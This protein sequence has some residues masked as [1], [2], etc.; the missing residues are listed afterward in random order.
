MKYLYVL[1]AVCISALCLAE[2]PEDWKKSIENGNISYTMKR[3]PPAELAPKEYNDVQRWGLMAGAVLAYHNHFF[4]DSFETS[5]VDN[6]WSMAEDKALLESSWGITCREDY[7][8]TMRSLFSAGHRAGFKRVSNYAG[9]INE[10]Y[11][12]D[13]FAGSVDKP[14][15]AYPLYIAKE[16]GPQ[17]KDKSITGWDFTRVIYLSRNCSKLG[18]ISEQLAWEYIYEASVIL[19]R[20]FDSWD[21]L[22][23]NYIIGRNFWSFSSS[24]ERNARFNNEIRRLKKVKDSSAFNLDWNLKLSKEKM[25]APGQQADI[26]TEPVEM[27]FELSKSIQLSDIKEQF[28]NVISVPSDCKTIEKAMERAQAGDCIYA[29]KGTYYF[30]EPLVFKTGVSLIGQSRDEVVL[31]VIKTNSQVIKLK[32]AMDVKLCN[33]TVKQTAFNFD[34]ENTSSLLGLGKSSCAVENLK[35]EGKSLYGIYSRGDKVKIINCE[36]DTKQLCIYLR[37][38]K[39]EIKGCL[40][41]GSSKIGIKNKSS[42][43]TVSDTY[44]A[45]KGAGIA[46]FSA[47]LYVADC[48]IENNRYGISSQKSSKMN[49]SDTFIVSNDT[50]CI[51]QGC[52]NFVVSDVQFVG[53]SFGFR[54]N[55]AENSKTERNLFYLN[56]MQ[57]C[58]IRGDVESLNLK[59]NI[60]RKNGFAGLDIES[61]FS[62]QLIVDN[63]L[64]DEN[65][66]FAMH[67]S[68]VG[69]NLKGNI[70]TRTNGPALYLT[71]CPQYDP[72]DGNEFIDNYGI[73]VL[74]SKSVDEFCEKTTSITRN[75][76]FKNNSSLLNISHEP[77][78]EHGWP[79]DK[80][81]KY[82]KKLEETKEKAEEIEESEG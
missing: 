80:Y 69:V 47:D 25:F 82:M 79:L 48:F 70:F 72:I 16:F 3:N 45:G 43:L 15:E 9:K 21:E 14:G 78:I 52:N 26:E 38:K 29:E 54:I 20:T 77:E 8:S 12:D 57:G 74:V 30:Q 61:R 28:E 11:F 5:C 35:V 27:N 23:D 7:L 55:F 73:P 75:N 64:F 42:E 19:Q 18:Y 33:F 17:L 10:K 41:S 63:N 49:I 50:G 53:N 66:K 44:I 6:K 32:D 31:S 60:F 1:A 67:A 68:S 58:R 62:K 2:I 22:F 81:L 40:L 37:C 65:V 76:K 13:I 4:L 59:S 51:V 24:L 46:N 36:V 34:K 56:H 39:A 71:S